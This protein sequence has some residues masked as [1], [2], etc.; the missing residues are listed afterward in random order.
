MMA[1]CTEWCRGCDY[2]KKFAG[3]CEGGIIYCDYICMEN[4]P[5][6]CPAGTGCTVRRING[7][8][9]DE[10]LRKLTAE[11]KVARRREQVRE[12]AKRY[13]ERHREERKAYMRE[14]NRDNRERIN[15]QNRERIRKKREEQ[16]KNG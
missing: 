12:N 5:R 7:L 14:Y 16:R 4:K 15:Q 2:Q 6:P 13:Y 1:V 8:P 10:Q 11:Q 9:D 3:G